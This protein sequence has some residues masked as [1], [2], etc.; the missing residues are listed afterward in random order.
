MM[1]GMSNCKAITPITSL[2]RTPLSGWPPGCAA[3]CRAGCS[4]RA[5]R[6]SS[7][8]RPLR[9]GRPGWV[10]FGSRGTRKNRRR[11]CKRAAGGVAQVA[12]GRD[13]AES[14]IVAGP[15]MAVADDLG[16]QALAVAGTVQMDIA[17][18]AEMLH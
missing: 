14:P 7:R 18:F 2:F 12:M 3:L 8:R 10:W 1:K 9:Q 15:D 6:S 16:N 11:L 17:V 4:A 5:R 13:D